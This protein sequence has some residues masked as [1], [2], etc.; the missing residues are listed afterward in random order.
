VVPA[1][2]EAQFAN[3]DLYTL[4][5]P[6]P[7][8]PG[9]SGDWVLWFSERINAGDAGA[10]ISAPIPAGKM[11]SS[12]T[13][14]SPLAPATSITVQFAAIVDKSGHILSAKILRS[15]ADADARRKALEE[16]ET[17]DFKPALRNGSPIDVDV[18]L[19]VPLQLRLDA[20]APR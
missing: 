2:V 7:D 20:L 13:T 17:W 1:T 4:V 8:L 9:Y 5:I 15:K 16:L 18:V 10:H 19:E 11:S 3:R 14:V 6:A 12:E